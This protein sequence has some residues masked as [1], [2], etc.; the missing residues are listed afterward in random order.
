M[1][2]SRWLT[3]ASKGT[4]IPWATSQ[5]EIARQLTELGMSAIRFTNQRDR[6]ALEFVVTLPDREHPRGVRISV[7]LRTHREDANQREREVNRLHRMLFHHL[8]SK[9][10]VIAAGLSDFEAEFMP[11]LVITDHH[12]HA[13]PLGEAWLPAYRKARESGAHP[14]VQLWGGGSQ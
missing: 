12:G 1:K 2:K 14:D 6:F 8:Q 4:D 9:F 5:A 11:H 3:A 7:P 10:V 13:R